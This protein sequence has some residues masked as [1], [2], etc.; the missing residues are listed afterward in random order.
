MGGEQEETQLSCRHVVSVQERGQRGGADLCGRGSCSGGPELAACGPKRSRCGQLAGEEAS[1]GDQKFT[2]LLCA[3]KDE[4][5]KTRRRRQRK[6]EDFF[7][8]HREEDHQMS[9]QQENLL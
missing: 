8:S 4:R 3:Q 7:L 9:R 6:L 5:T 2:L 1:P